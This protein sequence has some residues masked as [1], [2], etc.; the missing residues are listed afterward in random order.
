M[1][2]TRREHEHAVLKFEDVPLM[3]TLQCIVVVV[4][5]GDEYFSFYGQ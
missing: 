5:D 3:Y 1:V 4:V 2:H